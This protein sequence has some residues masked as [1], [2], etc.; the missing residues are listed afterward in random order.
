M[1]AK[2]MDS[3]I[4]SSTFVEP[5]IPNAVFLSDT[6]V[7]GTQVVEGMVTLRGQAPLGGTV[8]NM[9]SDSQAAFVPES[10]FV[11]ENDFYALFNVSTLAVGSTSI[12]TITADA[13]G[14]TAAK[15]FTIQPAQLQLV[16]LSRLKTKA[17]D[18]RITGK[19][20][21]LGSAPAQG[22]T[23]TLSASSPALL[24]PPSVFIP[25]GATQGTFTASTAGITSFQTVR[26]TASLNSQSVFTDIVILP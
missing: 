19:V 13:G 20:F 26:L 4:T 9:S 22:Y 2:I 10:I 5:P 3:T 18:S 24:V 1:I 7:I 21:M 8:V 14:A 12:A 25:S 15:S 6:S 23:V 11:P 16:F 17:N